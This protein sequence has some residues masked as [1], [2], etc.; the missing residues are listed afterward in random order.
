MQ[1]G[2]VFS[3]KQKKWDTIEPVAYPIILAEK[4]AI[5]LDLMLSVSIHLL[6]FSIH[7]LHQLQAAQH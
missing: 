7:L 6:S 2:L 3:W 5:T 4:F 1:C